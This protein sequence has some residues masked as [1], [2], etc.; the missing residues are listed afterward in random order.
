MRLTR[1]GII[2]ISVGIA[3][4]LLIIL[5]LTSRHHEPVKVEPTPTPIDLSILTKENFWAVYEYN[6]DSDTDSSYVGNGYIE[7]GDTVNIGGE[8]VNIAAIQTIQIKMVSKDN[9]DRTYTDV[10]RADRWHSYHFIFD[11]TPN[12]LEPKEGYNKQIITYYKTNVFAKEKQEDSFEIQ[13]DAGTNNL[14]DLLTSDNVEIEFAPNIGF[15]KLKILDVKEIIAANYGDKKR[16]EYNLTISLVDNYV[17]IYLLEP[18]QIKVLSGN[19][20]NNKPVGETSYAFTIV[21]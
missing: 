4:I 12:I 11:K 10:K 13:V 20:I 18:K 7:V 3:C 2:I 17:P 1:R 15:R 9:V 6:S 21:K 19:T 5:L 14:K 16:M 8:L